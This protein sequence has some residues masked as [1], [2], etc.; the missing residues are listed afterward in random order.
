MNAQLPSNESARLEVLHQLQILD[1]PPEKVFDDLTT[2]AAYI[3]HTPIALMT[4]VDAERQWFKSKVGLDFN[5]TDRAI[6]FCAHAI[7]GINDVFVIPDAQ[8]DERFASNPLVTGEP[9]IR[10]Y[11]GATLVTSDGYLLGTLCVLDRQPRDVTP[12]QLDALRTLRRSIMTELALRRTVAGRDEIQV[13]LQQAKAIITDHEQVKKDIHHANRALRTLSEGVEATIRAEHKI[14]LLD[15]ICRI[16]VEIGGYALAWIGEVAHDEARQVLPVA[17]AGFE[18]GYLETITITWADTEHGRGPT[19]TA[20]RSQQPVIA[21]NIVDDPR[22]MPWR[23]QALRRGFASSIALPILTQN[24]VRYVLNIYAAE[25]DS[26]DKHEVNLL[27]ELGSS[28]AY[29][30]Q[31]LQTREAQRKSE[32]QFYSAFEYSASGM[33]L[34]GLDGRFLQVNQRMSAIFG[35]SAAEFQQKHFNDITF[36][37]DYDIGTA[38]ARQMVDGEVPYVTFEKRYMRQGG[39]VFWARITS[40]LLRDPAA[41]PLHF[42]TQVDD[43]SWQKQAEQALKESEE[44]FRR[45]LENIPYVVTIYDRDLR[46]QYINA[47]TRQITGRPT[48]DFIG[49]REEEIWPPE[50]YQVYLPTLQEAFST[51]TICTLTTSLLLP[52]GGSRNLTITCVPLLD[53]TGEVREVLGITQDFS[54]Q[55]R[56]EEQLRLAIQAANVGLWDWDLRTNQVYYSPEWKRQIGYEDHE[57]TNEFYEWMNRVHPEDVQRSLQTVN[58]FIANPWPNYHLEFRFRHKDGSYRSILTQASLLFDGQGTPFRMLGSHIDVTE[59]KQI[60]EKIQE[61]EDLLYEMSRIAQIGAWEFD[62]VTLTGSWSAEAA[63]I[64]G[65]EPGDEATIESGF[66]VYKPDSRALLE[67]AVHQ[68]LEQ[69]TPYDLELE[70]VTPAGEQK[71]ARSIGQPIWQ[72]DQ[73]IKVRG[74]VQD[75]SHR[76]RSEGKLRESEFRYRQLLNVAPIGIAVHVEG[77]IVFTN[78]AGAKLLGAPSPDAFI[79]KPITS[80]IHPDNLQQAANRINRMI[81]GEEGLYPTEDRYVRMDGSIIPVEVMA[82]PLTYEGKMGVQV[83]VTDISE[84]KRAENVLRESEERFRTTLDAANIGLW[85][86]NLKTDLWYS[87]PT[88]FKMLGYDPEVDGQNREVWGSRTHPDDY[89]FVIQKMETVRDEGEAGFDIELRFRHKDGT[90]RWLNSVGRGIEFDAQGKTTRMFGLQIDI[91]ERKKAEEALR[92]SNERLT[93]LHQLDRDILRASSPEE[94]V[95]PVLQ[96]LYRLIPAPRI[97]VSLFDMDALEFVVFALSSQQDSLVGLNQRLPIVPNQQMKELE[98]GQIIVV[99]DLLAYVDAPS[100]ETVNRLIEEGLR[101]SLMV[102]LI[103]QGQLIGTLI[104][105]NTMPGYFTAEHEKIAGEVA[106]QLAIALHQSQLS[107]EIRRHTTQLEKRVAERTAELA[108]AKERAESADRLK[109]AF[110]AIMSHELR[111]PL[112]SIIGFTGILLQEL[113]GQL[114]PE[115]AKQ[116]GMVQ[117]SARHLLALINDVLDISKIEAG[118]LEVALAPFDARQVVEKVVQTSRALAEKKGLNLWLEIAPAV[119]ELTSDR[120]RVEQILINL[121][122]NAIKFTD[123]GEVGIRCWLENGRFLVR[124]SDTG[125]GIKPENINKLFQPFRQ[126]ETGLDRRVEGTG[127][128]L[129]ICQKLIE[130]LNGEISVTSEWGAGSAFTFALP[131]SLG[132]AQD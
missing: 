94:S 90:Y 64:H 91:T 80:I 77:K 114:N 68:L 100:P 127:L 71:W 129:S 44:R 43:I 23:E 59:R 5:E 105:A 104:L 118:Q 55:K 125:I 36:P 29:G 85:D 58:A 72:Q 4:L 7:L 11:A 111:T 47:A 18:A 98:T 52:N 2:L 76:K 86:W 70:L 106:N 54:E 28:V 65:F 30:L 53:E 3:C 13:A 39:A 27:E 46:I 61:S 16:L 41:Q 49:R 37:E 8:R 17:Y 115:Q 89:D 26:F 113:P 35:Y 6:S 33:C 31:A 20:V 14:Q 120:R 96:S 45:A 66:S 40:T 82:V 21:Q 121:V 102:P 51:G 12:E 24:Q 93:V 50:V 84:R 116:L 109:S 99:S 92:R 83:M 110:L 9:H 25:P 1:T 103:A 108:V 79:G 128:G 74:T 119:D 117:S 42:I 123:Q 107:E 56:V 95:R 60:E 19:G 22:F 69:A 57:I 132:S 15:D 87:T 81:A 63:R 10:F 75:I 38:V 112:N 126:I 32:D 78:P 101:S 62:P 131:L 130:L 34:T 97:S 122:N 124:V 88:Y 73:I 48:S 67:T